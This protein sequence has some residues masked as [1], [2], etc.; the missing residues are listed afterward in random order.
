MR[1]IILFFVTVINLGFAGTVF[2]NINIMG[3]APDLIICTIASMAILEKS[4][5]GAVIGLV[6]G[7]VLDLFTG[8]IGFYAIPYFVS[9]AMIFFV[10]KS[11]NYIDKFLLPALFAMGAYVIKELLFAL[12]AYMMNA[13]FSL[14]YMFIR[15][16]LPEAVLTGL[17]MLLIHFIFSKLYRSGSI[18]PKAQEDIKKLL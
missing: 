10:R 16:I 3:I 13:K 18:R 17:F 8:D 2:P 4:M 5:I 1:F 7:L 9:G 15:Y 14:S 11:V 12:L 6:C